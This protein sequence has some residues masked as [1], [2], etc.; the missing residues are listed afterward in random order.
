M[1]NLFFVTALIGLM[2]LTLSSCKNDDSSP[3]SDV[4]NTI[5]QGTWRITYFNDSGTDELYHFTGYNFTFKNGIVTATKSGSATVTGT[6]S[7]GNDDSQKKFIMNFGSAEPWE[8]L[9]ED[10]VV[11]ERTTSKIRLQHV[12]GGNGGTDT[13]TFEKN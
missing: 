4:T 12:S 3:S 1:K 13:L 11:L 8:E 6:Y 7:D 9:S 10:W 2:I 5:E